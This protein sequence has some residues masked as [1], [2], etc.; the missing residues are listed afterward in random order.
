[1]LKIFSVFDSKASAYMSPQFVP[2]TGD[3]IRS[4]C[5]IASDPSHVFHKFAED[6]TLF[7]VGEWDE[8]S[9]SFVLYETPRSL[10]KAIEASQRHKEHY[11]SV[12]NV[13]RDTGKLNESNLDMVG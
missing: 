12:R 1:M 9:C 5:N 4:F 8:L 11:F 13:S 3:A 10:M 2:S 6:F 7:E